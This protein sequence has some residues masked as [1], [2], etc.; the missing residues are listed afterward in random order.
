MVSA[1]AFTTE[2]L[3]AT[4]VDLCGQVKR[5]M[6]TAYHRKVD[7]H[8]CRAIATNA[9]IDQ[10]TRDAMKPAPMPVETDEEFSASFLRRY[11]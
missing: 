2:D 11:L 5:A 6:A 9:V 7:E 8:V 10:L 4:G 1:F 3:S